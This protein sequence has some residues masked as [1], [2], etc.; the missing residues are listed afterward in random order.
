MTS[1]A[2]ILGTRGIAPECMAWHPFLGPNDMM[3]MGRSQFSQLDW[4]LAIVGEDLTLGPCCASGR[5]LIKCG[6][7]RSNLPLSELRSPIPLPIHINDPCPSSTR[8]SRLQLASHAAV[9]ISTT[10]SLLD[11][12]NA[13]SL[14]T[15]TYP[16]R[17]SL[18]P[19]P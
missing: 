6:V 13:S 4:L 10:S 18:W 9:I 15:I 1:W 17:V 16:Y 7:T 3:F 2:T 11:S 14:G 5:W 8:S 12:A 19:L